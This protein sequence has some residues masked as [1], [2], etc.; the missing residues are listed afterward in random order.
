[1]LLRATLRGKRIECLDVEGQ[2]FW[3][4]E[5]FD[6]WIR[7][8]YELEKAIRYVERNPVHAGLVQ[9]EE[10]WEWSSACAPRPS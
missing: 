7:D 3:Q 5:S 2:P 6:R 9:R 1:M 4:H 8:R 10:D